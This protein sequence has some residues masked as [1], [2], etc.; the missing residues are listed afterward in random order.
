MQLRLE[1]A[2]T[3][4]LEDSEGRLKISDIAMNC[5]FNELSYFHRCFRR[6]FG[7]SPAKFRAMLRPG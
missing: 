4:L 2:Q 1:K 7:A 3:L 6:R 5:G